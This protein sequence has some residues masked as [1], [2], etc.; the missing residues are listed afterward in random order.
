MT[1]SQRFTLSEFDDLLSDLEGNIRQ[2]KKEDPSKLKN[3]ASSSSSSS[4]SSSDGGNDMDELLADLDTYVANNSISTNP[5]PVE[6][7][8]SEPPTPSHAPHIS[9]KN[10]PQKPRDTSPSP[11]RS[12]HSSI[13]TKP[14]VQSPTRSPSGSITRKISNTSNIPSPAVKKV[15]GSKNSSPSVSANHSRS[16]SPIVNR[17]GSTALKSNPEPKSTKSAE[18]K[19]TPPS[20]ASV[21]SSPRPIVVEEARPVPKTPVTHVSK[22]PPAQPG[23]INYRLVGPQSSIVGSIAT[24]TLFSEDSNGTPI[25][26]NLPEIS[27]TATGPVVVYGIP[28]HKGPGETII[29]FTPPRS[30]NYNIELTIRGR[31]MFSQHMQV[32]DPYSRDQPGGGYNPSGSHGSSS[33]LGPQP[34][35]EI[36]FQVR[37]EGLHSG[38]VGKIS[39]FSINVTSQHG[40]PIQLRREDIVVLVS[41]GQTL[42]A[43]ILDN[44]AGNY[45]AEWKP[46]VPG[47]YFVD[48]KWS[49]KSVFGQ[50]TEVVVS[51]YA[52][53]AHSIILN[54][55]QRPPLNQKSHFIVKARNAHGADLTRGGDSFEVTCSGPKSPTGLVLRDNNNGEYTIEFT[56]LAPGRY[57]FAVSLNGTDIQGSPVDLHA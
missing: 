27:A 32:S 40:R 51:D 8:E 54:V 5:H 33:A 35:E 52:S 31:P 46:T 3:V 4:S 24:Y 38:K 30:G 15:G 14:L 57:C 16:S 53:S 10:I 2:L 37:G 1:E 48:I 28:K 50:P 26:T 29:E 11:S 34:G 47:R 17:P 55:P 23:A 44:G 19:I 41:G 22:M 36:L 12:S 6:S 7:L 21:S 56:L 9:P 39:R 42:N 20:P 49:G 13:V 43:T 45:L 18:V 25:Y